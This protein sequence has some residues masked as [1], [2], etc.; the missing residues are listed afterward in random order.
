MAF[1]WLAGKHIIFCILASVIITNSESIL[2]G[3][4]GTG[5]LMV[6]S[7]LT[8]QN[9]KCSFSEEGYSLEITDRKC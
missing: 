2:F 8:G 7:Y 5:V 4:I 9:I 3:M 1:P 6:I